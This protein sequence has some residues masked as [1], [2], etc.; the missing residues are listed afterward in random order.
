[1]SVLIGQNQ[2]TDTR[3]NNKG[4]K[5]GTRKYLEIK[6]VSSGCTDLTYRGAEQI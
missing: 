1:M 4:T 5:R 2:T 3:T 6:L